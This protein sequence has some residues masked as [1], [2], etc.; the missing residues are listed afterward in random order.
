M[1]RR[2]REIFLK[3]SRFLARG[4]GTGNVPLI[5]GTF[6]TIPGV[7]AWYFLTDMFLYWGVVLLLF[8]VSVPGIQSLIEESGSSDP[9]SVVVDEILGFMVA[10]GFHQRDLVTGV[11]LFILFRFF[12]IVKPWPASLANRKEGVLFIVLD[13]LIAGV[14]AS[15]VHTILVMKVF[16]P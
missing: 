13:D 11:S 15:L 14:F 5:P 9:P 8:I 2:K 16:F 12:D 10:A 4:F 6:G 1:D 3:G 7:I